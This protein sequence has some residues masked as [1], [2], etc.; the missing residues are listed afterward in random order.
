MF[1]F[2]GDY[3]KSPDGSQWAEDRMD[4]L[5]TPFQVLHGGSNSHGIEV[6]RLL[7]LTRHPRKDQNSQYLI[8]SLSVHAQVDGYEAGN[9]AQPA[10]S[11]AIACCSVE[12]HCS[13]SAST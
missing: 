3:V 12:R 7:E 2:Q 10:S 6:G 11:T 8:T 5:Q 13:G 4:E 9:P 1:D